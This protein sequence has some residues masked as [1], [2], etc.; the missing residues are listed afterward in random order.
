MGPQALNDWRAFPVHRTPRPILLLDELPKVEGEAAGNAKTALLARRFELAG[1]L[2][3]HAGGKVTVLLSDGSASL[4]SITAAEAF[5]AMNALKGPV[6]GTPSPPLRI[7]GA[8][9]GSALFSTDRG[10]RTLPAWLFHSPAVSGDIAWPALTPEVFWRFDRLHH[11]SATV[12]FARLGADGRALTV[13]MPAP[14]TAC[15]GEPILQY[16]PV[17]RESETAVAIGLTTR[18]VGTAPGTVKEHCTT[19]AV[20]R[21]LPYRIRLAE[22]LGGRVLVDAAGAPATVSSE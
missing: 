7:T 10:P 14:P 3:E 19:P 16:D 17:F 4:D 6:E 1:T 11:P 18:T 5:E 9:L 13:T 2:P 21:T 12:G 8:T 20:F 22:P 15:P